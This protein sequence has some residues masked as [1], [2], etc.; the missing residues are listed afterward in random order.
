[1]AYKFYEKQDIMNDVFSR[2][3]SPYFLRSGLV[4]SS[5]S[6]FDS[7]N[8]LPVDVIGDFGIPDYDYISLTYIAAGQGA[9]EIETVLYYTGG[10]GGTL[11]ATLTLAYNAANEIESVTKS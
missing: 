7:S 2:Q 3:P 11:V 9:G 10:A 5:G 8:P 1:M 4:D 6:L